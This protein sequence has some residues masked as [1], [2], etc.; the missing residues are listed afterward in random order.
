[1]LLTLNQADVANAQLGI[2]LPVV[3]GFAS[4]RGNEVVN[5]TLNTKNRVVI[6]IF[7]EGEC[8]GLDALFINSVRANQADT[9]LIHFHPGIDGDLGHGLTP[10]SNGGDQHVDNFWSLLPANFIPTTFSRKCYI[11]L[12]V[13]PDPAAPTATLDVLAYLRGCKVRQ[14]DSSGNQTSYTFSTNGAWQ[15]MDAILRSAIK[16]EWNTSAAAAGGGDL[17]ADEK[18]RFDFASLADAAAWC[19]QTLAG[20]QKRFESSIVF[21]SQTTLADALTSLQAMSQLYVHEDSGKIY[22]RADKPRASSFILTTDHVIAGQAKFDKINLHGINNRLIGMYNDLNA[23][24]MADIVPPANSGLFR[25][26]HGQVGVVCQTNHPFSVGEYVQICAPIDGSVQDAAFEGTF[27][28][29]SLPAANQFTY[30]QNGNANWL[31]YSEQFDNDVW[32]KQTN[33][34]VAANN[35]SDPNGGN[36]ADT[37]SSGVTAGQ[38]IFQQ[39]LL[40]AANGVPMTFSV[41]LKAAANITVTLQM[42]RGSLV[43]NET[44]AVNVTTAWQRFTFTHSGTWSGTSNILA[45]IIMPVSSSL[46]VWGAQIEDGT[47]AT[48]YRQAIGVNLLLWSEQFSFS[49]WALSGGVITVTPDNQVD[50]L[51]GNTADTLALGGTAPGSILQTVSI[52][53]ANSNV[54]VTFSVWL[55]AGANTSVTLSI[56]RTGGDAESTTITVTNVWQRFTFTHS[57]AWTVAASLIATIQMNTASTSIFAWGAQLEVGP[58]ATTYQSNTSPL[59]IPGTLSGNGYVGTPES[60]FA[61][62]PAVDDH[63]LHQQAIGQ[64][65]LNLTPIFRVSPL[66]LNFG[67]NTDERV[68]R[69]LAFMNQ[70]QLGLKQTPYIAPWTAK[71]LCDMMAVDLS[72]AGNPRALL[73]QLCGDIITVDATISEEYQGDYEIRQAEFAFP[74][75]NTSSGGSISGSQTQAPTILLTLLQYLPGAYSDT[76]LV[77]QAVRAT[78][79]TKLV[80]ISI[81]DS[82]GFQRLAGTFRNNP[83]NSNGILTGSNPI[84]QSGNT[85]TINIAAFVMQ[86]GDGQVS[87]NSGS[88]NPGSYGT[89]GIYCIDP[90]F[91]GGAVTY[92]STQSTHIKTSNNGIVFVG[93]ITTAPGGGG[94]GSGG[95]AGAGDDSGGSHGLPGR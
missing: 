62:K 76:S 42:N 30:Q 27:P 69:A 77:A 21:P 31:Q 43:D 9:T 78:I 7:C 13:P 71:I 5:H 90:S 75:M 15:I 94:L 51:G 73:A 38:G 79:A 10:D 89:W 37:V 85:T 34:T 24:D 22:I 81:V 63:E 16:P 12:N 23:Q 49:A 1:M 48:T 19:D 64:R 66:T 95:G 26:G 84:T 61:V 74:S 67:N 14:F 20:G 88:L 83:V 72:Q 40:H 65:G 57:G 93:I 86:F 80:P 52:F 68:R 44:L 55:K 33:I 46:F 56:S 92:L 54:R 82:T 6:R 3:Y 87:Y 53:I 39:T 91:L 36:T 50:P 2:N 41:W 25:D 47:V 35:Q 60:R 18:A 58:A 70:R 32:E 59:N 29:N 45:F 11:M 4:G 17:T 8:D 28:I